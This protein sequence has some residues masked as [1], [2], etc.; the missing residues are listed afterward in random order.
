[1]VDPDVFESLCMYFAHELLRSYHAVRGA[2]VEL[3]DLRVHRYGTEGP[4]GMELEAGK[5]IDVGEDW[6]R[7]QR[8]R[9]KEAVAGTDREKMTAE[10]AKTENLQQTRDF[11]R[12]VRRG[13][14]DWDSKSRRGDIEVLRAKLLQDLEAA[15]EEAS[16]LPRNPS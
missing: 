10:E 6:K 2:W 4:L 12:L 5:L 16:K 14:Q 7:E 15:S 13:I 8:K 3:D 1:M 9:H 11:S